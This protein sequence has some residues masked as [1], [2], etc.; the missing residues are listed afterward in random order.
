MF[1]EVIWNLWA[2]SATSSD[3]NLDRKHIMRLPWDEPDT[4][5]QELTQEELEEVSKRF[6]RAA[7]EALANQ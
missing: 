2:S 3:F 7:T 6:D 4:V 5:C 1:R